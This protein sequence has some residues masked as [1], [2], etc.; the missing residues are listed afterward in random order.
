MPLS[1]IVAMT[2]RGVIGQGGRLPWWLP[3]DLKRFKALTMGHCLIMG[4]KTYQSLGRPLPGR[5]SIVVTRQA[6]F[7]R[8][9]E[10]LTAL[11]L[12]AALHLAA[13][14]DRPFVIGGGEIFAQAMDRVERMHVTWVEGDV[15]GDT[16][17]PVWRLEDWRLVE[18][19]RH[20][21]DSK[22]QYDY[23]FCTYNRLLTEYR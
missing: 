16:F 6:A 9:A 12:D 7:R 1:L 21:A 2:R 23:T 20:P 22:N 17:F 3:S 18:E 13:H 19:K 10:V 15:E 5:T 8:P 14:D 11:S 4:R